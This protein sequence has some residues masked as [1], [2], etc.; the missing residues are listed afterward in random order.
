MLVVVGGRRV[1]VHV[2]LVTLRPCPC[3]CVSAPRPRT[4]TNAFR[5]D[6]PEEDDDDDDGARQPR[7]H[8]TST[9]AATAAGAAA[10]ATTA[11]AATAHQAAMAA[12]AVAKLPATPRLRTR[13]FAAELL[14][15]LFGAVGPDSR[16]K[17]PQPKY[18]SSSSTTAAGNDDGQTGIDR[19]ACTHVGH[20]S[21]SQSSACA[22]CM[23]W[24]HTYMQ[25]ERVDWLYCQPPLNFPMFSHRPAHFSL[26]RPFCRL[27]QLCPQTSW[28]P[29]FKPWL[30]WG[31]S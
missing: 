17:Q 27:P 13:L 11:T 19:K 6:T 20:M 16:H 31:S 29:T 30:T 8:S 28:S 5:S 9:A 18:D 15:L 14:L 2:C 1:N 22:S 7:T 24:Q 4:A 10:A 26:S 25:P 23:V 12:A 21:A 3:A